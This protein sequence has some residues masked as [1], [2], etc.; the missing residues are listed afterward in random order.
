M[1]KIKLLLLLLA[2]GPT[3]LNAQTENEITVHD[4]RNGRDEII[5]LPEGMMLDSDSLL[6]EWHAQHYLYPDTTCATPDYNPPFS[7]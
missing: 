3:G 1:K 5:E 2:V 7:A 4:D 6:K